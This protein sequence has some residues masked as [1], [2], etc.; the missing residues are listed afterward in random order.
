MEE[1]Q[2]HPKGRGGWVVPK[3]PE[4]TP[5]ISGDGLHRGG[6]LGWRMDDLLRSAITWEL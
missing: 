5:G 3:K 6:K 4:A 1:S 2:W